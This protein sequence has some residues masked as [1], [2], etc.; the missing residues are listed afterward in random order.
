MLYIKQN[1]RLYINFYWFL[2]MLSHFS[3]VQHFVTPWTL[4]PDR[5]FL[6]MGFFR[7]EYWSG[8]PFP[9]PGDPPN[10]SIEPVSLKSPSLAIGFF[11]TS[12]TWEA[13]WHNVF[14]IYSYY[15]V[16]SVIHFFF[17]HS[18]LCHLDHLSVGG[19]LAG[20]QILARMT[21]NIH[22][23]FLRVNI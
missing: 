2:C 14:K 19:Y 13:P 15:F 8:L 10:L 5:A 12:A 3:R 22:V 9:P 17:L 16:L 6:A 18:I 4:Q 11:T 20:S 23:Q 1:H 7:Q 21:M